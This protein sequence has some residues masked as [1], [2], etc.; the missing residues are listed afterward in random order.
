MPAWNNIIIKCTYAVYND[1]ISVSVALG[2]YCFLLS[3]DLEFLCNSSLKCICWP[4]LYLVV[5]CL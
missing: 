4:K 5:L 1:Q 3:K 2:I